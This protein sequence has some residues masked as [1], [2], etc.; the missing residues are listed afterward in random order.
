[1]KKSTTFISALMILAVMFFNIPAFAVK[2]IVLVGNYF[3]NPSTVTVSVGDTVRW[4]WS[5][6][7]H[8]TT[9]GAIPGGAAS[10]DELITSSNTTYDYHVTVAGNYNYV[11]TPHAGMGMVASFTAVAFTPTL[12]VSP[13]NQVVSASAG[14]TTFAVTS[15]TNWTTASNANWCTVTTSGSG[16]GSIAA[17]YSENTSVIQR[18]AT[19]TIMVTGLT[20]QTVTLTQSGA[21]PTL[22]VG[23][24]NQ[25]VSAASGTTLFNVVSNT[26]WTSSSN[27]AWC[28]VTPSGNGNGSISAVFEANPSNL[29]R[30]ATITTAVSGLAPQTVTVTQAASTV[31]VGEQALSGLQVYPN[32][33]M[34]FFK[35]NTEN[36]ADQT[37]EVTIMDI[38]GKTI[39]SRICSGASDYSFDLSPESKGCYFMRIKIEG[40][41][42]VRRIVLI[43]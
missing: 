21:L 31:G 1:M 10:W 26:G 38:N 19:I 2:H 37:A 24:A 43:K 20:D 17:N 29:V 22:A 12:A 23:P 40:T 6:G 27:A 9:S 4:Q 32:P 18:V 35:L 8:T 34:G 3:F 16:N 15:N 11:C 42:T 7:S 13:A 30:V 33:T 41:S 25:N 28:T 14:I 5:A 39:L 36:F